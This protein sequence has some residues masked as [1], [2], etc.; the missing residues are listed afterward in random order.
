MEGRAVSSCINSLLFCQVYTQL[1]ED[2]KVRYQNEMNAWKEQMIE[3]GRKDLIKDERKP[4]RSKKN[5]AGV[6]DKPAKRVRS[7]SSE[8]AKGRKRSPAKR[9]E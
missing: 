5:L 8:A 6:D 9:E 3:I 1:A 7:K 2:D 4:H